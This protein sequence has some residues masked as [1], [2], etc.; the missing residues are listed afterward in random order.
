MYVHRY[1]SNNLSVIEKCIVISKE[2]EKGH[3]NESR[4][5]KI[6]EKV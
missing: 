5:Q 4:H 1:E 6:V 3:E 2:E